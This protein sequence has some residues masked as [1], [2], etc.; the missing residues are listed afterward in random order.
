MA[1]TKSAASRKPRQYGRQR[2][3]I[4]EKPH[5]LCCCPPN[6]LIWGSTR[7]HCCVVEAETEYKARL[8]NRAD[9]NVSRR[10]P[11]YNADGSGGSQIDTGTLKGM[12]VLVKIDEFTINWCAQGECRP[13]AVELSVHGLVQFHQ[14]CLK[15]EGEIV[16]SHW[17]GLEWKDLDTR[18]LETVIAELK[19]RDCAGNESV[20]SVTLW[21]A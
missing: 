1:K 16:L 9:A 17:S 8:M 15:D 6:A 10:D 18:Q 5:E 7:S 2:Q 21:E 4:K 11:D 3:E 14:H 13:L 12:A 19:V 20:C